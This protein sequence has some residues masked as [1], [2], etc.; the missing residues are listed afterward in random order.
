M[1][2]LHGNQ[3][4]TETAQQMQGPNQVERRE[5]FWLINIHVTVCCM[6]V[7]ASSGE[8]VSLLIVLYGRTIGWLTR[9]LTVAVKA[10]GFTKGS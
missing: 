9:T 5:V 6:S 7:D 8:P 3:C 4:L 1:H 2:S 10:L